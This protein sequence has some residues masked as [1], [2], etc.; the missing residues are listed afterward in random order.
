MKVFVANVTVQVVE[1]NL[2]RELADIVSP[3]VIAN[4]SDVELRHIASEPEESLQMRDDL[5]DRLKILK[6]GQTAFEEALGRI[7]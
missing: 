1:R 6:E 4:Y 5:E 7:R 3:K 2:V